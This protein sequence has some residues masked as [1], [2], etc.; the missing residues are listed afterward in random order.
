MNVFAPYPASIN[1]EHPS[2]IVAIHPEATPAVQ[3]LGFAE[4]EEIFY[5]TR[6][7]L[8]SVQ[9]IGLFQAYFDLCP[10]EQKVSIQLRDEVRTSQFHLMISNNSRF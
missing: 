6:G 4:K 8:G 5:E 2:T 10:P 1:T 9:A 7:Y 3:E